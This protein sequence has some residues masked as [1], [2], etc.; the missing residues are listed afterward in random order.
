MLR[1]KRFVAWGGTGA[2]PP[3]I[4]SAPAL[5]TQ[6]ANGKVCIKD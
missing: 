2:P 4:G 5:K 6:T 1:D 3:G